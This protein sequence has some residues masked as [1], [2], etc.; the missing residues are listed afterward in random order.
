MNQEEF[1]KNLTAKEV[2]DLFEQALQ[3]VSRPPHERVLN[4]A[5]LCQMLDVS[6][7]TTATWR[8]TDMLA[9]HKVGGIIF[10]L[11]ADVLA[12]IER[13]RI[14]PASSNLKIKL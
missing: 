4:D 2:S 8:A 14:E 7:R 12:M 13:Y 6:K 9:H 10:Y 1:R 3:E 5:Q 11:Y